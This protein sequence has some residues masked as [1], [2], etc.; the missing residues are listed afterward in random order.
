MGYRTTKLDSNHAGIVKHLRSHGYEVLDMSAVGKYP[1][2]LV[3]RRS[4]ETS[5]LE[6]K[7]EGSNA[8]YTPKQLAF[9]SSTRFNVGFAKTK[10][11][12]VEVLAERRFLTQKQKDDIALMLINKPKNL[13]TPR[14]IE[15][16]LNTSPGC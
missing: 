10:D 11:E 15:A 12:A 14:E 7:V 3:C 5:F 16:V 8:R 13:Y 1:D 4:D 6:L 2:L 9:I